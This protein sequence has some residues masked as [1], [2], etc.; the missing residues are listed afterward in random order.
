MNFFII[1]ILWQYTYNPN[2]SKQLI[3]TPAKKSLIMH[4]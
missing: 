4:D 3:I 2:E 1:I